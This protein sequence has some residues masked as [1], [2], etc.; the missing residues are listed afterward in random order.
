MAYSA[1]GTTVAVALKNGIVSFWDPETVLE[2]KSWQAH[3]QPLL[4]IAFSPA[5]RLFTSA[6]SDG[7]VKVWDV[8]SNELQKSLSIAPEGKTLAPGTISNVSIA[9]SPDGTFLAVVTPISSKFW[10]TITWN[11]TQRFYGRG[12]SIP[13]GANCV[14]LSSD[15]SRCAIADTKG[16][17]IT[18]RDGPLVHYNIKAEGVHRHLIFS[19]D[20]NLIRSTQGTFDVVKMQRVRWP[21]AMRKRF[22]AEV[23]LDEG[24]VID[25]LGRRCCWV[26]EAFRQDDCY[27]AHE[28]RVVFAGNGRLMFVKLQLE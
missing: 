4:A 25:D 14:A 18:D 24:W 28:N 3:A 21:R 7:V 2:R 17:F 8:D 20:S 19:N 15:N 11:E 22:P 23:F 9:F 26:P 16:I 6:S 10:D 27:A 13:K 5:G 1:N 12:S